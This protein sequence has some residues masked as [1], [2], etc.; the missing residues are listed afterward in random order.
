MIKYIPV[1]LAGMFLVPFLCAES[2]PPLENAENSSTT[3]SL[4]LSNPAMEETKTAL[5][6][7]PAQP[8]SK[9]IYEYLAPNPGEAG[10]PIRTVECVSQTASADGSIRVV[11]ETTDSG[12]QVR[13]R[14]VLKKTWVDHYA[15]ADRTF[16][17]DFVFK[18][19]KSGNLPAWSIQEENG[20]LHTS[21][22]SFGQVQ[23]GSNNF[24]DCVVVTEK[25]LKGENTLFTV[26]YYYARGIG[27]VSMQVYS[28]S[29][30]LLPEQ[31]FILSSGPTAASN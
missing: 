8:G 10:K 11:M 24:S 18:L 19:P 27:L 15:R 29:G 6:Y 26:N 13:D 23:A 12:R 22:A 1:I 16:T 20:T 25:V 31:S 21:T 17:G 5:D 7:F 4:S 30:L 2:L 28:V 9:W 14:Y 3:N